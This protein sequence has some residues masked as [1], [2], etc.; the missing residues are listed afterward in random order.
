M[1]PLSTKVAIVTGASRG[2]GRAI[3]LKLASKGTS[4]V[5]N[6]ATNGQ[7]AQ[8][9][10][11]AIEKIGGKALA[12]QAD[13]SK[14]VEIEKLF[15]RTIESFRKVDILVKNAG[16]IVYKPITQ[17]TEAEFDEIFAT[18]VKGT[19]FACQQAAQRMVDGGRIIN[20]SSTTT[21]M[22]L[23]TYSVYAATKGAVEQITRIVAKELGSRGITVNAISPGPTDTELFRQDKTEEQINYL[24]QASAL[25]RLGQVEDIANVVAFLASDEAQWITGQTIRANGGLA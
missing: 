18:N 2:I 8:E 15:D 19:Y 4:V 6:Y 17:V 9:V 11:T 24:A 10:V 12:V 13:V 22:M 16:I 1:A 3:A 14:L 20:V 23:P 25:G 21:A 7:K 5:V